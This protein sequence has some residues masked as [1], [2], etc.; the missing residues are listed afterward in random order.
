[1]AISGL[2]KTNCE[3]SSSSGCLWVTNLW[4]TVSQGRVAAAFGVKD[5]LVRTGVGGGQ[6]QLTMGLLHHEDMGDVAEVIDAAMQVL[7]LGLEGQA[8]VHYLW[9]SVVRGV[10]NSSFWE[11]EAGS[12]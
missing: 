1:M 3:A 9:W 11:R 8:A 2:A 5:G 10:R 6:G 12:E 7:G 4:T